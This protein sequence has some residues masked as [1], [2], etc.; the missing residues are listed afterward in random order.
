MPCGRNNLWIA[1]RNLNS[2]TKP[3]EQRMKEIAK[4]I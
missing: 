4:K 1:K 3:S 2:V